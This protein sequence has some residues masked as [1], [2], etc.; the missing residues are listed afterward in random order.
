MRDKELKLYEAITN[1][2]D[3][4][5]V[6]PQKSKVNW[7]RIVA[8]AAMFVMIIGIGAVALGKEN[9]LKIDDTPSIENPI[10]E[11]TDIPEETAPISDSYVT[12]VPK[13]DQP[14]DNTT[15][16]NPVTENT[17]NSEDEPLLDLP[18]IPFSFNHGGTGFEGY[19]VYDISELVNANPA[20]VYNVP[21]KLPVYKNNIYYSYPDHITLGADYDAM[22]AILEEYAAKLDITDYDIKTDEPDEER[23]EKIIKYLSPEGKELASMEHFNLNLAWIE[24]EDIKIEVDIHFRVSIYYKNGEELPEDLNFN[25]YSSYD[26]LS[27]IAEY[28]SEEYSLYFEDME[29][30]TTNIYGGY[31]SFISY[32]NEYDL[33]FFDNSGSDVDKIL[34]YNFKS[35]RFSSNSDGKLWIIRPD[36][37]INAELLGD[38]PTISYE[39]AEKMLYEG[40]YMT[41]VTEFTVTEDSVVEKAELVYRSGGEEEYYLPYYK[42]YI[43]IGRDR[44]GM[45]TYSAF[46]VPAI[47]PEYLENVEVWD[48]QFN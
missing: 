26:E 48:G 17:E 11:V 4:L 29:S 30:P 2:D 42:F 6:R 38:Y 14:V 32:K 31:F 8:I 44:E 20:D 19:N 43:D 7:L 25:F 9:K 36:R 3:K 21:N 45:K 27:D 39:E 13:T 12:D 47:A 40:K 10:P 41:T 15:I 16:E 35:V 24:T 37:E 46:Y 18:I 22:V 34:N 5:L 1:I 28:I 23:K 33:G